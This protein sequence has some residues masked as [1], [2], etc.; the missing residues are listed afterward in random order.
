MALHW[1]V[2]FYNKED[3][4]IPYEDYNTPFFRLY[5]IV[6]GEIEHYA[7]SDFVIYANLAVNSDLI[8][9]DAPPNA[10]STLSSLWTG[11]SL[12]FYIYQ[13]NDSELAVMYRVVDFMAPDRE[14]YKEILI[15]PIEDGIQ[16]QVSESL[17]VE[18]I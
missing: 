18:D 1:K 14:E 17:I 13:R 15:I 16:V 6:D 10:L 12:Q 7:G 2:V 11:L 5:L 3:Y 4:I 8:V 9:L